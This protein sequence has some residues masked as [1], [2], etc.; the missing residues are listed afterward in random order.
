MNPHTLKEGE[1]VV[2][3]SRCNEFPVIEPK[4]Y[5]E[6]VHEDGETNHHRCDTP[7]ATKLVSGGYAC[8]NRSHSRHGILTI[9]V[10][11]R[12]SRFCGLHL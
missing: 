5:P 9:G 11:P 4:T 2:C 10:G 8:E 3:G 6:V 1:N 7:W 12:A